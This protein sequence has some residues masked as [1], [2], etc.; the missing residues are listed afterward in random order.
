MDETLT[1]AHHHL[2]DEIPQFAQM[3]RKQRNL[4]ILRR[5]RRGDSLRLI[6][7]QLTWFPP[8]PH[9]KKDPIA[10]LKLYPGIDPDQWE[11]RTKPSA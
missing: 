4:D 1:L 2:T 10:I 9:I 6:D 5:M 11:E 3:L 8:R 7:P